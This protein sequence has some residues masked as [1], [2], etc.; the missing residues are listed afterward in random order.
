MPMAGSPPWARSDHS[1]PG[2]G[3]VAAACQLAYWYHQFLHPLWNRIAVASRRASGDGRTAAAAT[4][5]LDRIRIDRTH[6]A[7]SIDP[8]PVT[9]YKVEQ[10]HAADWDRR[11]RFQSAAICARAEDWVNSKEG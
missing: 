9:I 5:D 8:D 7:G 11:R 6:I 2:H 3:T 4:A 1:W 10:I